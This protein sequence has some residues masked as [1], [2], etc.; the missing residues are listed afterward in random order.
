MLDFSDKD[1]YKIKPNSNEEFDYLIDNLKQIGQRNINIDK[2]SYLFVYSDSVGWTHDV[3]YFNAHDN[4]FITVEEFIKL[5]KPKKDVIN[6]HVSNENSEKLSYIEKWLN[7]EKIQ[8]HL[9]VFTDGKS[10]WHNLNEKALQYIKRGDIKFRV[11]P[12]YLTINGVEFKD[13]DRL[14]KYVKNNYDLNE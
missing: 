14:I 7:G 12:K 10:Q 4:E 6:D 1:G 11:T 3:T 5:I 13:M 2:E 8:Y 9:G